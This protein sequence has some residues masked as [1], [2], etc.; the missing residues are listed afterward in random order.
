MHCAVA[1]AW[2]SVWVEKEKEGEREEVSGQGKEEY[3]S[4]KGRNGTREGVREKKK[5]EDIVGEEERQG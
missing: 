4:R 3:K 1:R 5:N 2:Q